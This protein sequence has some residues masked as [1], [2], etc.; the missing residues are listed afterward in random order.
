MD[1]SNADEVSGIP[2]P[3]AGWGSGVMDTDTTG[4]MQNPN[5]STDQFGNCDPGMTDGPLGS[6][7]VPA[8]MGGVGVYSTGVDTGT[9]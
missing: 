1:L 9:V 4:S 6:Y 7:S 3:I 8:G 2:G 5:L